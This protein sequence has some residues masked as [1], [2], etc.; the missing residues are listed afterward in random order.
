ML[1]GYGGGLGFGRNQ[2]GISL[3]ALFP[4]RRHRQEGG[5]EIYISTLK[6]PFSV[7]QFVVVVVFFQRRRKMLVRSGWFE[8]S[9]VSSDQGGRG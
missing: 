5:A 7:S 4:P 3:V 6:L 1:P 9:E 8:R 2:A